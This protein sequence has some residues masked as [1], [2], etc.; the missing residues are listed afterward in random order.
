MLKWHV[1]KDQYLFLEN[2]SN[3]V[4][5]QVAGLWRPPLTDFVDRWRVRH[6][7]RVQITD[8]LQSQY[9]HIIVPNKETA[10]I[11]TAAYESNGS[12]LTKA[13]GPVFSF[14]EGTFPSKERVFFAPALLSSRENFYVTDSHWNHLGATRYFKAALGAFGLP[15]HAL[16]VDELVTGWEEYSFQGDLGLH[17]GL[18]PE[19]S[20][21]PKHDPQPNLLFENEVINEGYV[22]HYVNDKAPILEKVFVMHDSTV[23]RLYETFASIFREVLFI[24]C[25]DLD[26]SFIG[27]YAPDKVFFLQME[28]FA[29]RL[30]SNELSL[31][32]FVASKEEQK[33]K[34]RS[35]VDYIQSIC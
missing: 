14:L 31:L 8:T 5:L 2:D 16:L 7:I 12:L 34:S 17:A 32:D 6:T 24:H 21:R 9:Y 11:T 35:S 29:V 20:L 3:H 33:G 27:R 10:L 25:P 22:R 1:G 30:G 23:H 13:S 15:F 19:L 4:W 28:R 18:G 26:P